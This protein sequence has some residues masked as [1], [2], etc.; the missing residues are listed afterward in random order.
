MNRGAIAFYL[1]TS[2]HSGVDRIMS[3]LIEEFS[4]RGIHIDLLRIAKHGPYLQ[5][6]PGNVRLVELGT[7]HVNNSFLPLV[8]YLRREKPAALLSDKDRLNRIAIL[9]RRVAG[10]DTRIAVRIGT[11]VSEN[12]AKRGWLD[13]T[14]QYLSIRN[15]YPKAD[16]IIVPS[17]GAAEDLARV[18][19]FALQHISVLP[20]P[21]ITSDF[22]KISGQDIA[23]PWFQE[24][25]PPVIVGVGELC[26]RKDFSTLIEA[27]ALLRK[28]LECRLLLLGEGR[29][30]SQ[31]EEQVKSMGLDDQVMMPGFVEN[32]YPLM[33]HSSLFV[34]SSIC[35]GFGIVLAEALAL[36]VPAVSTD[37]PSGPREILQNGKYGPLVP[38]KDAEALS[39]A[40]EKTL[41]APASPDFLREAVK[42]YTVV[43]SASRYLHTLGL[44]GHSNAV[45]QK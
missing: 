37:C 31:L 16:E 41:L 14:L 29:Q 25:S 12:L 23:H 44:A 42:P 24:G 21:V 43:A 4:R 36:G 15:L 7:A 40:M 28:R 11:T 38:V 6:I 5:E 26:A 45:P 10:V 30:R 2:G 19:R 18:G 17:Q 35:E 8:R 39:A 9:A 3:N 33:A 1:A 13:R 27:F 22:E 20:N 34:L 32:P